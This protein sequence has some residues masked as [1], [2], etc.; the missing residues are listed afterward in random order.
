MKRQPPTV[1][2][3]KEAFR[4]PLPSDESKKEKEWEG[5]SK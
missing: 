3:P 4:E 5:D 1:I 2:Q